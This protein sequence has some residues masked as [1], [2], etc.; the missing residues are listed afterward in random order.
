MSDWLPSSCTER[1]WTLIACTLILGVT[2]VSSIGIIHSYRELTPCEVELEKME[3]EH[4]LE[5]YRILHAK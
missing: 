2:V 4:H 5:K 1:A 3:L